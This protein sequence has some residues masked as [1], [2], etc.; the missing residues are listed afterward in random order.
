MSLI[1]DD[2][3]KDLL[4]RVDIVDVVGRTVELKKH[5]ANYFGRCP[6]H[7][8]KSPSFSVSPSKQFYHCFG[9][10]ANGTALRFVMEQTGMDFR[11]AVVD[12]AQEV[13]MQP[14]D[15]T[16]GKQSKDAADISRVLDMAA[17]HY[18]KDLFGTPR[19]RE[20]ARTRGLTQGTAVRFEIGYAQPGWDGLKAVFGKGYEAED[21]VKA[22][23]V[24]TGE[25]N[26]RYDRFRDRLMFPIHSP[27][28]KVIA[29]GGRCIGDAKG[30]PKYL[31]S[32]EIE[33]FEKGKELYGL[34][35]AKQAIKE[36]DAV[37]VVEGYM[38]VVLMSQC[39]VQNAVASLGT[40]CTEFHIRKLLRMT[41]RI[42]FCFD[43]DEAGRK[44]ARRALENSLSQVG[45]ENFISFM[46]LPD[47]MDPD[48][49]V[50]QH[51]A[52]GFEQLTQQ[53]MPL[54]QFLLE[55]VESEV[56]MRSAEGRAKLMS[57]A[58]PHLERM[59]NAPGLRMTVF[60]MLAERVGLS[61]AEAQRAMGVDYSQGA[62]A[63]AVVRAEKPSIYKGML[64]VVLAKPED[65]HRINDEWVSGED[66]YGAA[67]RHVMLLSNSL[68][69]TEPAAY[70]WELLSQ[71]QWAS[72]YNESRVRLQSGA[73]N[74][75]NWEAVFSDGI[76]QLEANWRDEQLK[77]LM[78]LEKQRPL[79]IDELN[80]YMEHSN[81]IRELR[82]KVGAA[83]AA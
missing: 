5:G 13:G 50:K 29:F 71:S 27:S 43:G 44:A 41:S 22:G 48:D 37:Y 67:L 31:N 42:H 59:T 28:G 33:G 57:V 70:I 26:K 45:D 21:L 4:S 61:G 74:D 14:P 39:G 72:L 75:E 24:V 11:E 56:D 2:Y 6:F 66:A 20:Y 9:C 38:D 53:A 16:G 52:Q 65:A 7:S 10:G 3:L 68:D 12:L 18:H 34:Y 83:A 15:L 46:F 64:E 1:P 8:E 60:K 76:K 77:E 62:A 32:P 79:A 51:G 17:K 25:G 35:Q 40:A 49:Y 78:I 73:I 69:G 82:M 30:E 80:R 19:A 58:K 23:L 63:A 36:K 54:S 81:R 47:G 55:T